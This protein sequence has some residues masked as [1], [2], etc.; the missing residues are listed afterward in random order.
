MGIN[1][2]ALV[3]TQIG[4]NYMLVDITSIFKSGYVSFCK[5]ELNCG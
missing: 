5:R 4:L 3:G 2:L 1:S